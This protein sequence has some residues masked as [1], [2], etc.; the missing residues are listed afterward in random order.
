MLIYRFRVTSEDYDD[1]LRVV[2]IQP[3]QTFLDFHEIIM[4][5]ADID[6]CDK[7]FFYLTDNKFKK[8]KEISLKLLKKQVRKYDDELDE[9]VTEERVPY[10]MKDSRLKEHVEDPHQRMIYEFQGKETFALFIELFKII[11]TDENIS[12]P[13]C[14]QSKGEIPKKLDIPV[15]AVTAPPEE[16]APIHMPLV[17][18]GGA[19]LFS[20]IHEDETELTEIENNLG[21]LIATGESVEG[22]ESP[23]LMPDDEAAYSMH[24]ASEADEMEEEH[25]ESL[26][27]YDD[28]ENLEINRRDFDRESDDF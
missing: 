21:D 9:I 27:E 28:I 16:E 26:D 24:Q 12:L 10:L 15:T 4:T 6:K 23:A 8:E 19:S 18:P 20:N 7:A 22:E 2:E 5:S 3:G 13:R 1:F 14:V 25:I 17:A 11:K